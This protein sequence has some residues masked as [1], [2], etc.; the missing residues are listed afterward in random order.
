MAWK[1]SSA[2]ARDC[3]SAFDGPSRTVLVIS[4]PVGLASRDK[5]DATGRAVETESGLRIE[6]GQVRRWESLETHSRYGRMR[7]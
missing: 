6:P 3:V 5:R 2:S 1:Y 4:H 7:V